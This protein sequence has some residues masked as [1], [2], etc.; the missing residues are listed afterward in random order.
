[1][2]IPCGFFIFLPCV[3]SS[4]LITLSNSY[5]L[6]HAQFAFAAD[7]SFDAPEWARR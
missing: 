1:M 7:P 3:D 6:S 5:L 2:L 4:D